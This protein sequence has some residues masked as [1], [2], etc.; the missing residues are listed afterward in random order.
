MWGLSA[1]TRSVNS[2]WPP[3]LSAIPLEVIEPE[4]N[5]TPT[6]CPSLRPVV[7]HRPA[8]NVDVAGERGEVAHAEA[9]Q[10]AGEV[11]ALALPARPLADGERRIGRRV[12]CHEH[13]RR[14]P[15]L[16]RGG[17]ARQAV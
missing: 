16:P 8:K 12:E 13:H 5:S 2:S 10:L 4:T 11:V 7:V 1:V 6:G 9:V 14:A 15:Q 3:K 17:G